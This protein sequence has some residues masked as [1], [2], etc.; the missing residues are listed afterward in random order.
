MLRGSVLDAPE[1]HASRVPA[2]PERAGERASA[3]AATQAGGG[4]PASLG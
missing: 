1:C 2:A 4:C 3:L